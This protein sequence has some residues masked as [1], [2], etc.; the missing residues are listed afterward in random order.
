M[1]TGFLSV[2]E[3]ARIL[4]ITRQAV[5][6]RIGTGR[7]EAAKVGRNY[8]IP[9]S[10]V[11]PGAEASGPILTEV[12]RR[13]VASYEPERIYLFGS[14]A[15]GDR[16]PHSDYDILLVL[17]DDTPDELLRARRAYEVLWGVGASVDVVVWRRSAFD[18]RSQVTTS[19][20]ATVLA[21]GLLLHAG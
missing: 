19:L 21:E 6:K 12:V 1:D 20:P 18:A 13:L 9:A 5:L 16:T 11:Q 8:V 3:A 10:A 15:R 2:A 14:A 7:L 4:G 17:P